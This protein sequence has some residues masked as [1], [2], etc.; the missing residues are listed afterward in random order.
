VA[1]EE[2][3]EAD[4]FGVTTARPG[5]TMDEEEGAPRSPRPVQVGG[6]TPALDLDG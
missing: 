5:E 2:P 1:G 3:S 4:E 6:E